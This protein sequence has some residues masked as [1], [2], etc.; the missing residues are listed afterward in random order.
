MT[1]KCYS[2]PEVVDLK[3]VNSV[4]DGL[5][6]HIRASSAPSVTTARLRHAG[7]PLLQVLV[8][9]R[10]LAVAQGKP[11]TVKAKRGGTLSALLATYGLDPSLCG[12]P[13]DLAPP[14]PD[15]STQRT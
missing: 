5:L 2:L 11:F 13:A 6:Q 8:A 14:E 7:L 10:K 1:K 3:S 12:A 15:H 4:S 9:A